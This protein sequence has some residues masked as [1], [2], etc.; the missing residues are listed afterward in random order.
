MTS[1][2]LTAKRKS[3]VYVIC[4]NYPRYSNTDLAF[5]RLY[6]NLSQLSS[7]FSRINLETNLYKFKAFEPF[8]SIQLQL[9]TSSKSSGFTIAPASVKHSARSCIRI[10]LNDLRER[11]LVRK[12][13]LC[14]GFSNRVFL[15][16]YWKFIN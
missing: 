15:T 14:F 3:F 13:L 6:M 7:Y 12:I 16:D 4:S 5:A 2:Y 10:F 8:S 11:R 9:N 1:A